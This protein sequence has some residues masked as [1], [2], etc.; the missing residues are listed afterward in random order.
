MVGDLPLETSEDD[1]L[2]CSAWETSVL[3]HRQPLR[4]VFLLNCCHLSLFTDLVWRY[5]HSSPI[6]SIAGK[7][8]AGNDW[9]SKGLLFFPPSISC[10]TSCSFSNWLQPTYSCPKLLVFTINTFHYLCVETKVKH[11]NQSNGKRKETKISNVK[12]VWSFSPL[13]TIRISLK[14]RLDFSPLLF[15]SVVFH[16]YQ[17]PDEFSSGLSPPTGGPMDSSS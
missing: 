13:F 11:D 16:L 15:L 4:F 8:E 2:Y 14:E 5:K 17:D 3:L 12:A 10:V 1:S 9:E 7:T 6:C